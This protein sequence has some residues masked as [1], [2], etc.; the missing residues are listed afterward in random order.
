VRTSFGKEQT[1]CQDENVRAARVLIQATEDVQKGLT[2]DDFD[3]YYEV[4]EMFDET[5][6]Q[7]LPLSRLSEFVDT[8]EEPLRLPAPNYCKLITLDIPIYEGDV[9]HCIDVLDAL[10]QNYLGTTRDVTGELGDLK[11][12]PERARYRLATSTMMRRREEY[13]A[14]IIQTAWRQLVLE[15]RAK[16][17]SETEA[18]LVVAQSRVAF[19][20]SP[21]VE[22]RTP[23]GA[24]DAAAVVAPLD[25]ISEI[26]TGSS[27]ESNKVDQDTEASRDQ[28]PISTTV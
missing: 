20:P 5:C 13:C 4:W 16:R 11:K 23:P 6:T 27:T 19:A 9:V 1:F 7:F 25:S 26:S 15:G 17:R 21:V 28:P 8:L 3:M 22:C 12:G 18:A 2:Q 24:S 14:R 10:A